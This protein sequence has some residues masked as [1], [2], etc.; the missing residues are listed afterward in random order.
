MTFSYH[1]DSNDAQELAWCSSSSS[2]RQ[3]IGSSIFGKYSPRGFSR[4]R[5]LSKSSADYYSL[6]SSNMCY[7]CLKCVKKIT[8]VQLLSVFREQVLPGIET[9][10]AVFQTSL[11]FACFGVHRCTLEK[12]LPSFRSSFFDVLPSCT[13]LRWTCRGPRHT[14]AL[15]WGEGWGLWWYQCDLPEGAGSSRA[16][17]VLLKQKFL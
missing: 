15:C 12:S 5:W 16:V 1:L 9:V 11:Q 2:L 7:S 13:V 10:S 8:V 4:A 17:Q 14:G 3:I 6:T